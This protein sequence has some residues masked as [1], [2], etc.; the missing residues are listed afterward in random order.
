MDNNPCQ[1]EVNL[2]H[3]SNTSTRPPKVQIPP[4][5]W[6]KRVKRDSKYWELWNVLWRDFTTFTLF[7]RHE[8]LSEK[9][10]HPPYTYYLHNETSETELRTKSQD[11]K[12]SRWTQTQTRLKNMTVQVIC[13]LLF[14]PKSITGKDSE[15]KG[16]IFDNPYMF[17]EKIQWRPWLEVLK[18]VFTSLDGPI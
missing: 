2:L 1:K 13:K 7:I 9:N 5:D 16:W 8:R 6:T 14:L 15:E 4:K 18:T 17:W 12:Y 11:S 10:L 3:S